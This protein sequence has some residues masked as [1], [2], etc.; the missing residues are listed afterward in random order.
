MDISSQTT[1]VTMDMGSFECPCRQP[2]GDS[3][4]EE[5]FVFES[6]LVCELRHEEESLERY[7]VTLRKRIM[8]QKNIL[9]DIEKTQTHVAETIQKIAQ[10]RASVVKEQDIKMFPDATE[11]IN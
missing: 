1:Q 6:D 10:L 5:M 4:D 9:A 11:I 7:E 2:F 3:D 8:Q